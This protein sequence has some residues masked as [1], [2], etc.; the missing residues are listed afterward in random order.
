[1]NTKRENEQSSSDEQINAK[2]ILN[3]SMYRQSLPSHS[4]TQHAGC[5]VAGG[6][7]G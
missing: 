5:D 6:D 1:M 2:A 7:S 3:C 4:K